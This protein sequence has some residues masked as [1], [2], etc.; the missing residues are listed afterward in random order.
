MHSST[1]KNGKDGT[2]HEL[3]PLAADQVLSL[4]TEQQHSSPTK[5]DHAGIVTPVPSTND[6]RTK[7]PKRPF[8][9][10]SS[11]DCSE[12]GFAAFA[13]RHRLFQSFHDTYLRNNADYRTGHMWGGVDP[14]QQ[15]YF[16]PQ[17]FIH[18]VNVPER[19]FMFHEDRNQNRRYLTETKNSPNGVIDV[20][21]KIS[22]GESSKLVLVG[23]RR[24]S[25][26]GI[27]SRSLTM[28][29]INNETKNDPA[30]KSWFFSNV[31]TS[32]EKRAP[33]KAPNTL[34]E[35]RQHHSTDVAP[36]VRSSEF[37]RAPHIPCH[38]AESA[39]LELCKHD[40]LLGRGGHSITHSGNVQM[41]QV[42]VD[43]LPAY[44][45]GSM[46]AKS[47][48]VDQVVRYVFAHGGRFLERK[49]GFG[50]IVISRKESRE[51]VKQ[52]FREEASGRTKKKPKSRM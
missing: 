12:G 51:K 38:G 42:I 37:S 10:V 29:P 46:V 21:D 35:L 50:W 13:K 4:P 48:I 32:S 25:Q 30:S 20:S 17:G 14:S 11:L 24:S 34:L 41:R 26:D 49:N 1:S 52:R 44:S 45:R 8:E 9:D 36:V 22:S 33:K 39:V 3:P 40:V 16:E 19:R 15:F 6:T 23:G 31:L 47:R 27:Q 18:P 43:W 2:E 5:K 28:A 7:F